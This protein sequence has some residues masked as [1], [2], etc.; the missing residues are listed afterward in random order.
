[1]QV[2]PPEEA[3]CDESGWCDLSEDHKSLREQLEEYIRKYVEGVPH[4]VGEG[5][6]EEWRTPILVA[7]YGSGKT[8]LMRYLFRYCWRQLKVPALLV[9][10]SEIVRFAK[11][12]GLG[13]REKIQED[14]LPEIVEKLF[15]LKLNEI[16]IS[17]EKN[18][19]LPDEFAPYGKKLEEYLLPASELVNIIEKYN[20][21]GTGVLFIDEVEETYKDL[22]AII[23]YGTSPFRG[24]ADKIKDHASRVFTI[25]AFGPSAALREVSSGPAAWRIV[26]L[27][28]PFLSKENIK[29]IL[30]QQ[31]E[32][33]DYLDLLSNTMWWLSRGRIAWVYKLINEKVPSNIVNYLN[34]NKIDLLKDVLMSDALSATQ[35]IEGVP[36]LDG[37]E[38]QQLLR[39]T[40]NKEYAKL[41][42]ITSALVGPIPVDQL[43]KWGIDENILSFVPRNWFVVGRAFYSVEDLTAAIVEKLKARLEKEGLKE[44]AVKRAESLVRKVLGAWSLEGKLLYNPEAPKAL[45]SLEDLKDLAADYAYDVYRDEP[46]IGEALREL[47]LEALNIR[48]ENAGTLH[49]AL[50]P[51]VIKTIFPPAVLVPE[52]GAAKGVSVKELYDEVD[53]LLDDLDEMNR[54]S[55]KVKNILNLSALKEVLM[56]VYPSKAREKE[57]RRAVLEYFKKTKERI[58]VLL[59]GPE[60]NSEELMEELSKSMLFKTIAYAAPLTER[61]AI[62]LASLLYNLARDESYVEELARGGEKVDKLDKGVFE[63][64]NYLLRV[65]I[66][67]AQIKMRERGKILD[68]DILNSIGSILE[69]KGREIGSLQAYLFYLNVAF[70]ENIKYLDKV[71]ECLK[72]AKKSYEEL[73][74][75]ISREIYP[76]G[77]DVRKVLDDELFSDINLICDYGRR[78]LTRVTD[79][80]NKIKETEGLRNLIDEISGLLSFHDAIVDSDKFI[81]NVNQIANLVKDIIMKSSEYISESIAKDLAYI[82]VS[83]ILKEKDFDIQP[84]TINEVP[85]KLNNFIAGFINPAI[86]ALDRVERSLKNFEVNISRRISEIRSTLQNLMKDI[87]DLKELARVREGI[88][89]KV[90]VKECLL[91]LSLIDGIRLEG[92]RQARGTKGFLNVFVE[93]I[94]NHDEYIRSL[95]E[96]IENLEKS[97]EK[98]ENVIREIEDQSRLLEIAN[99]TYDELME[100]IKYDLS[101]LSEMRIYEMNQYIENICEIINTMITKLK[102][103]EDEILKYSDPE[104][105]RLISKILSDVYGG[106]I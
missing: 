71:I 85:I 60:K 96:K 47:R 48:T 6:R 33:K 31:L 82:L 78:F 63:W 59:V 42:L 105:K 40:T 100:S 83:H 27:D 99:V 36:L 103:F 44:E 86:R 64:Y 50:S 51:T 77:L 15:E 35:I 37:H 95:R 70:P 84:N 55:T 49:V 43:K 10:L 76:E 80:S 30:E 14:K 18:K 57:I 4:L 20:A 24:L 3:Y 75:I 29:R 41:L 54:Y 61:A 7:P 28:I 38:L 39:S 91:R 1:M 92:G 89:M 79:L 13:V 93:N 74:K 72:N 67:E 46:Q 66:N 65:Q 73:I 12:R 17:I 98:L 69:A 94:F 2:L 26:R 32:I 104:V 21:G 106:S 90:K 53:K 101:S 22:T 5:G 97:L 25:L 62:Y 19:K 56:F 23:S 8:T 88:G 34:E 68:E 52:F 102:S 16:K 58:I 81:D 87:N 45:K 11:Q 9:N